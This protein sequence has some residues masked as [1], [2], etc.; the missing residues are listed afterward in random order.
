MKIGI[1]I[2]MTDWLGNIS[3]IAKRAEAL[4]FESIWVPEH[5]F[6]PVH[7]ASPYGGTPD[8]KIPE[9]MLHT[10]NPFIALSS[11]S[12]A[13]STIKLG[14]GVCLVPQHH[15]LDLASQVATL[16]MYSKGRFLFGVGS[17]WLQEEGEICGV[18]WTHRG[19]HLRESM[20]AMKELWTKEESEYHGKYI[21]FPLLRANP[22]PTQKPHPPIIVGG[23]APSVFKR[24]VAWGNG[25]MPTGQVDIELIRR[26][27]ATIDQLATEAG[28]DPASIDIGL[29][30]LPSNPD[31]VDQYEEVGVERL[32]IRLI[33]SGHPHSPQ[34]ALDAL[35]KVAEDMLR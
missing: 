21:D 19:A 24:V 9:T 6:I 22:K 15:V 11:A 8:G 26:G 14:T 32:V 20:L 4:G 27:R 33:P 31:L 28:R 5:V 35:D 2:P 1:F 17:G 25:W 18:D 23:T 34:A 29:F 10:V 30:N 12:A 16:D 3:P 7:T 13:T